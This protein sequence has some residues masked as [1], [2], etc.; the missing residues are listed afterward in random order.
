MAEQGYPAWV[1]EFL[2]ADEAAYQ[3]SVGGLTAIQALPLPVY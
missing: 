1:D 3:D 2:G